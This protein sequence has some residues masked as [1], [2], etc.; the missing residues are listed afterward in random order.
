MCLS[1]RGID[2][3]RKA[4]HEDSKSRLRGRITMLIAKETAKNVDHK[5]A[6]WRLAKVA[7]GP[8]TPNLRTSSYKKES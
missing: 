4:R 6:I 2:K 7:D 3:N 8:T 5:S 1:L